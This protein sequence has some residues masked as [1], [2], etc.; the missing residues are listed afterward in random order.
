[1][2]NVLSVLRHT[3]EILCMHKI[4]GRTRRTTTY[5]SVLW[6]TP[7]LC[8]TYAERMQRTPTYGKNISYVGIRWR[9]TL[10]CEHP[11]THSRTRDQWTNFNSI[12]DEYYNVNITH[13]SVMTLAYFMARSTWVPYALDRVRLLKCHLK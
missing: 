10:W 4:S 11:F 9:Y 13:D 12:V 5:A 2:S 3:L 6:R 7:N 8:K 1:M